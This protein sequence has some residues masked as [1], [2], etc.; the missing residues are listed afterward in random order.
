MAIITDTDTG[1]ELRRSPYKT[2]WKLAWPQLVMMFFHFLIG[3]V[4]V[5]V[6]G[7]LG[8]DVQACM[9]MVSQAMFFFL[10]VALALANGTVAAI[11]QSAGAGLCRRVQRY[12]GLSLEI[13]VVSGLVI[14]VPVLMFRE[15][16]LS[17]L[18]VPPDLEPIMGY[19]LE[20]FLYLTP[21]YY[22]FVI[23]NAIFRAQKKVLCPL[24]AMILVT[25]VNTIG[26]LGLGLGMFGLPALGYKGL[27]WATFGSILCGTV[28]N[29]VVLGRLGLLH[30]NSF[31]PWRWVKRAWP[32]LFKVSWPAGL[33]QIV[34]HSAYMVL[35]ALTASLPENSVVAMA[36]MS[37]GI[38]VE[39]LL[40][41]PGMAFN[42]TASILIGHYLGAGEFEEAKRFGYRIMTF[43]VVLISCSTALL[44]TVVE[45]LASF[46]AP[47]P[48][49]Q[50]E[51][52]RYLAYNM[53]AMPFLLAAMILGGAFTG[54]GATIYQTFISGGASWLV[55][56][57]LAY[58][59]GHLVLRS[60]T[61][62]WM[63]MF[64]SMVV[65]SMIMLYVYQFKAWH[66]FSMRSGKRIRPAPE[67]E[68]IFDTSTKNETST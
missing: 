33:S 34:W 11:S 64:I 10:V 3:F 38:R 46:L 14:L 9:G 49:V 43:G 8:R 31:A 52:V 66:R 62:I 67:Q 19:M 37:A 25:T 36:G 51:T 61:G 24:Y 29:L 40:F 23:C 26:D 56:L 55:R 41:L 1:A 57:P 65:Q 6:A 59:L 53:A 48:Q 45:P 63:A 22:L 35:Y 39:S 15:T 20:V 32:Y 7:K 42:F 12:V 60:S 47:D 18:Q 5:W 54:A 50:A 13:G 4:D 68:C 2:I 21:A 27:A 30:R 58:I 16:F 44:W 17:L 28:F